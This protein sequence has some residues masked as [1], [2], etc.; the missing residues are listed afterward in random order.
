MEGN[1]HVEKI[2][3]ILREHGVGLTGLPYNRVYEK[4]WNVVTEVESEA[5]TKAAA[6]YGTAATRLFPNG[7]DGDARPQSS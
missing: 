1:K 6:M 3:G 4:I 5:T 7:G 2:M